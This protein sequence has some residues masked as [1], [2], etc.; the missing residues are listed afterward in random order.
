[1]KKDLIVRAWKDP[2]FRAGLSTEERAALPECPAGRSLT[3][4][5]EG[6]LADV[7]GGYLG[8]DQNI[9]DFPRRLTP[10]ISVNPY[11]RLDRVALVD[12]GALLYKY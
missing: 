10:Y 3:D 6:S 8:P 11:V 9:N 1:M 2:E 12:A 5:D 4:L 7:V